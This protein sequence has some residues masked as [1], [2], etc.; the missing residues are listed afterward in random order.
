M[1][2]KSKNP[3]KRFPIPKYL[4]MRNRVRALA[5]INPLLVLA[6]TKE[7]EKRSDVNKTIKN[8]G[9]TPIVSGSVK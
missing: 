1:T 5:A 8:T 7:K 9:T 3:F 2:P 4:R 6:R